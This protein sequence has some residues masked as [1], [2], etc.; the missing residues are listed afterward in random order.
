MNEAEWR[1]ERD[2]RSLRYAGRVLDPDRWIL[3]RADPA[4]AARYDGQVA[5]LVAANLLGRMTPAL[6]LD[7]PS[8]PIVEPLPWAGADLRTF[9]REQ[10]FAADPF[11]RFTCRDTRDGDY[12]LH[13]GRAGGPSI[14]HGSG[15]NLYAGPAPSPLANDDTAN[16]I[17]PGMAAILAGAEAFRGALSHQPAFQLNALTWQTGM[18]SPGDAPLPAAPSPGVLWFV[19]LGS[20][21]TAI[22]Y[23]LT[24]ATRRFAARLFDMDE[25]EIHNLDRSP[26]FMARHVGLKKVEAAADYLTE[27]GVSAV[28]ADPLALDEAP[29]WQGRPPGIP[30]ILVSAA[31]ERNVRTVIEN[32]YPPLQ[33]YGTT[34][35][36]WQAA[37]VRHMP[38]EDP[39]SCCLFPEADHAPTACATGPAQRG[40]GG[41]Q[42]DAALPF[43][44]FAAGVMAAAEILKC[45]F[46]GYPFTQ[47]RVIL[48]TDP[49]VRAVPVALSK[50]PDCI[51]GQRSAPV[52]RQMLGLPA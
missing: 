52:H 48:N 33:I 46:P 13:L 35:R 10:L 29:A 32:G 42:M 44:S 47:N 4:Y 9:V 31:N 7:V 37:V 21:G 39:C 1:V 18:A 15:W 17:G 26:V 2:S 23:F 12:I 14:V 51:C 38:L 36:H 50:R 3:L 40:E 6:A 49:A 8:V 24:L 25:V 45:G 43:L 34:G 28:E 16:P 22:A 20:V 11:G 30:D 5:I 41:A 27:S 19:G